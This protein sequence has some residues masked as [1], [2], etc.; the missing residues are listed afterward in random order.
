[1]GPND[2][3]KLHQDRMSALLQQYGPD[4]ESGTPARDNQSWANVLP[5]LAAATYREQDDNDSIASSVE[6]A[7]HSDV[8]EIPER[9]FNF[10]TPINIYARLSTG[11]LS[12][13]DLTS[14]HVA[15]LTEQVIESFAEVVGPLIEEKAISLKLSVEYYDYDQTSE[16]ATFQR[17]MDVVEQYLINFMFGHPVLTSSDFMKEICFAFTLTS[18]TMN[19]VY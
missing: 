14:R 11:R 12:T 4:A 15:Y 7:H 3:R 13:R 19:M 18:E 17:Q 6:S 2:I 5:T 10:V 1:M 9:A 8:E 16:V